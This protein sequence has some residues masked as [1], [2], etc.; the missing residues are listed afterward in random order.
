MDYEK[1]KERISQRFGDSLKRVEIKANWLEIE[2]NPEK[3]TEV[4]SALKEE[5]FNYLMC[6]SGADYPTER[7]E[8]VYHLC[9]L[10]SNNKAVIKTSVSREDP[11]IKS[12]INIWRAAD[13]QEREIFDLYGVIFEN[14]PDLRRILMPEDWVGYPLRKDYQDSKMV[15]MKQK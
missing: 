10:P 12:V 15:V 14:H 9:S 7:I 2:I 11:S 8:I 6:V 3:I 1:I 4:S 13:W 5:G